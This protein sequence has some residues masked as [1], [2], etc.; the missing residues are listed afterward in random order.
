LN[1]SD[2]LLPQLETNKED[3]EGE[4]EEER[5]VRF[6]TIEIN[7]HVVDVASGSLPRSGAPIGIGWE[8]QARFE[9]DVEDYEALRPGPPRRG[10][11]MV[12]TRKQRTDILLA[13]GSTMSE[14]NRQTVKCDELRRQRANTSRKSHS[15]TVALMRRLVKHK[16]R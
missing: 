2:E 5:H 16:R 11:Q 1:L 6:G 9:V 7:E 8:R 15:I 10:E 4:E 13:W 3:R 14:V 12:M